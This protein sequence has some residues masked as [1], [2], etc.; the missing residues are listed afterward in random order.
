M[1]GK[2]SVHKV[3]CEYVVVIIDNYTKFTLLTYVI[4]NTSTSMPLKKVM[5]TFKVPKQIISD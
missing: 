2:L 4:Y 3:K 1:A 5:S